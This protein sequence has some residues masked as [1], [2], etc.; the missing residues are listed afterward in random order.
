MYFLLINVKLFASCSV[1]KPKLWQCH[2]NCKIWWKMVEDGGGWWM[3][4]DD[5]GGW[6]RM[7]DDGGV[8]WMMVEDGGGW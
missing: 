1:V 7:V 4:V 6:W 2:Y 3:M 8:W 5:G